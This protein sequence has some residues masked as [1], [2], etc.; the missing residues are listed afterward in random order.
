MQGLG[1]KEQV[2]LPEFVDNPHAYIQ[3]S[4]VFLLSSDYEEFG[5][6]LVDALAVGCPT[7][8]TDCPSGCYEILEGGKWGLLTPVADPKAMAHALAQV[9]ANPELAQRLT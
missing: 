5:C 8:T 6:V 3:R 9:L 4:Q 7:V 2:F 1:L